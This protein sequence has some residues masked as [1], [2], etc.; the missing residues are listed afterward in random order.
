MDLSKIKSS[1]ENKVIAILTI[2]AAVIAL[3]SAV[4]GFLSFG[5]GV[6]HWFLTVL[7]TVGG[8]VWTLIPIIAFLVYFIVLYKKPK[9]QIIVAA[10]FA[11]FAI[12]HLVSMVGEFADMF[13]GF[14]SGIGYILGSMI[15]NLFD[16]VWE[17]ILAAAFILSAICVLWG[18]NKKKIPMILL[19]LTALNSASAFFAAFGSSFYGLSTGFFTFIGRLISSF[20][21]L[22]SA[23]FAVALFIF[24]WKNTLPAT[25][26]AKFKPVK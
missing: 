11:V 21:Y 14:G 12:S 16:G 18:L 15:S 1:K 3:I 25:L 2:V 17:L 13:S 20:G 24:V 9:M 22:G 19:A 23:A 6:G 5:D 8:L 7:K 10:V 4:P 26:D